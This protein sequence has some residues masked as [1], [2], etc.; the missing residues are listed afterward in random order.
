MPFS[1]NSLVN[2]IFLIIFINISFYIFLILEFSKEFK[3]LFF[4][5]IWLL[6][7]YNKAL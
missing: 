6:D 7:Y 4:Y 2:I 1:L 5:N 3:S